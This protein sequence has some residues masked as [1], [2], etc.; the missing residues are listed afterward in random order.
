MAIDWDK[1]IIVHQS[2]PPLRWFANGCGTIGHYF[3]GKYIY[4]QYD[5]ENEQKAEFW[6]SIAM[7]FYVPNRRWGTYFKFEIETD[8]I[9]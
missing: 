3:L 8:D 2:K 9:I 1:P 6:L 4:W 5:Q 7:K